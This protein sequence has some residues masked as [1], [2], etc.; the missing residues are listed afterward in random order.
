MKIYG[1][2]DEGVGEES[3]LY[4]LLQLPVLCYKDSPSVIGCP[5]EKSLD[6]L[7]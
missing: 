7:R 5:S 2:E 4:I 3:I 1:D 6:L